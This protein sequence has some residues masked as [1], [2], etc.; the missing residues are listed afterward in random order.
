MHRFGPETLEGFPHTPLQ[1]YRETDFA[2][3]RTGKCG[4]ALRREHLHFMSASLQ[5]ID[6]LPQGADHTVRLR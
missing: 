1:A 4:E 2:I 3:A 6:G 5:V